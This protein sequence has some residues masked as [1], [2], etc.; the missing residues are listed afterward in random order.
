MNTANLAVEF[1]T[2]DETIRDRGGIDYFAG[3]EHPAIAD[4]C[5]AYR[6]SAIFALEND[7]RANRLRAE[8]PKNGRSL[9]SQWCGAHWGYSA[10]GIGAMAR[11]LTYDELAA[12]DAAND[13]GLEAARKVIDDRD[14]DA[15]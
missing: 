12:I 2:A 10:G 9:H 13:A 4:A 15:R 11:D 7:Y 3:L 6:Q 14:A 1:A 8:A 5:A